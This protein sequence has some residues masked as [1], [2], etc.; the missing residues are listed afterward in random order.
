[1]LVRNL[2]FKN[3][4]LS[5]EGDL[6]YSLPFILSFISRVFSVCAPSLVG[7]YYLHPP[8]PHPPPPVPY[9]YIITYYVMARACKW[10]LRSVLGGGGGTNRKDP[11]SLNYASF[12][13]RAETRDTC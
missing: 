10:G 5:A 9:F 13:F 2:S 3:H 12:K 11:I 7:A 1:M 4:Q 8:P 6:C